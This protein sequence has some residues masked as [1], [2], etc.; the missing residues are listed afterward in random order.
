MLKGFGGQLYNAVHIRRAS[1]DPV[2]ATVLVCTISLSLSLMAALVTNSWQ[3]IYLYA[4]VAIYHAMQNDA[5]LL[6]QR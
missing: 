1:R 3:K 2:H 4:L 6:S 5:L